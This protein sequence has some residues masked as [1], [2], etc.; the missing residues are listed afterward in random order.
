MPIL[1]L[2]HA[3]ERRSVPISGRVWIGRDATC[4]LVVNHP[5]V[6]RRHAFVE[7]NGTDASAVVTDNHSRNGI[8]VAGQ[9]LEAPHTLRDGDI[10]QIGPAT[11]AFHTVEPDLEIEAPSVD[12][13]EVAGLVFACDGCDARLWAPR[14]AGGASTLCPQC[15]RKVRVPGAEPQRGTVAAAVARAVGAEICPVCQWK[16][17]P[18]EPSTD[19]PACGATYHTECWTENRGCA[20]YGC[21]QANALA[22][23][24]SAGDAGDA[25]TG[26]EAPAIAMADED[27]VASLSPDDTAAAAALARRPN[28]VALETLPDR[29]P[30][31][32]PSSVEVPLIA[33]AVIASMVG[34]VAYGAPAAVIACVAFGYMLV[35]RGR[36]RALLALATLI[37]FVGA[38]AGVLASLYWWMGLEPSKL[39]GP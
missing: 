10:F 19:C 25:P 33:S 22:D 1:I 7:L 31:G 8:L 2:E 36:S 12:S 4:E 15:R 5:I 3:G 37:G 23:A 16:V 18:V 24:S 26:T 14:G 13:A 34:L 35:R 38:V 39:I 9:R 29:G 32:A 11:I 20:V 28:V 21:A 17:E 27:L 30:G 6:S